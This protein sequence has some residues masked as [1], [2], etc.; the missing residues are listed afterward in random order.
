M[1]SHLGQPSVGHG[2]CHVRVVRLAA[3]VG[4]GA[5]VE[6]A[7]ARFGGGVPGDVA[8][9]EDQDVEVGVAL[10]AA[11]LTALGGTGLVDDTET[12]AVQVDAG[13]LG[14][15]GAA[16]PGRRCCRTPR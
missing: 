10:G 4:R 8:V 1:H 2:R 11:P 13:D 5:R 12:Q 7:Q 16:G 9:S 14:K 3:A 6:Q 15:A